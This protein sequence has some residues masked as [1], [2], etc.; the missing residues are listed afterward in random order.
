VIEIPPALSPAILRTLAESLETGRISPPYRSM[1]VGDVVRGH[2][3][4]EL[5]QRLTSLADRGFDP[6]QIAVLL[7]SIAVERESARKSADGIELV[8]SGPE[9]LGST[10]RDTA[11]VVDELFASARTSVL[12]SGYAV[13]QGK[14]VFQRLAENM[15]SNP[16]LRVRLFLNVKR[17][18]HDARSDAELLREFAE[19]FR[20]EQWPDSRLPEVFYDPRALSREVGPRSCLHAKCVVIDRERAFVTSANFTEAAQE[21]NIEA[22]ILLS[23]RQVAESLESQ[24]DRLREKGLLTQVLGLA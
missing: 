23:S 18:F 7:R 11:V 2:P 3:G 1:S 6:F 8:W 17:E 12:V 5:T 16:N 4:V 10:T 24:F 20:A 22:G 13:Y 21:R 9:I 14:R 19:S 15:A